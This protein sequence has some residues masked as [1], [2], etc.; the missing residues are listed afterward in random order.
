MNNCSN[1]FLLSSIACKLSD[2]L[3]DDELAILSADLM[4]LGDMIASNLARKTKYKNDV[5]C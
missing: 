5:E 4:T 3:S 2:C 1:L